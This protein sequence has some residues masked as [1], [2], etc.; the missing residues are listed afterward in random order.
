MALAGAP[1][2]RSHKTATSG[3]VDLDLHAGS[4]ASAEGP[5]D[6]EILVML[7]KGPLAWVVSVAQT[8]PPPAQK[9]GKKEGE[10]GG[11]GPGRREGWVAGLGC[12]GGWVAAFCLAV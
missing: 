8:G 10:D 11:S 6:L 9:G 4:L 7:K 5:V 3:P 2:F 12:L 1:N